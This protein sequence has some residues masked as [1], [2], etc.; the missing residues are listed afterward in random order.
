M[1]RYRRKVNYNFLICMNALQTVIDYLNQDR[2]I[3][4]MTIVKL[5]EMEEGARGCS[6]RLYT[7]IFR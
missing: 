7:N 1:Y 4:G 2:C 5:G 3:E 6:E